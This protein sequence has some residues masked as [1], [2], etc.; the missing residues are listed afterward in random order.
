M[1][2]SQQP[3]LQIRH[4]GDLARADAV[5]HIGM[6][7]AGTGGGARRVEQDR[8]ERLLRHPFQR[9]GDHDFRDKPGARKVFANPVEPLGAVIERGHLPAGSGE[10][11]RLAAG[12]RAAIEHAAALA[13]PQQPRGQAGGKIL[14]PPRAFG[15]ALQLLDRRCR[16]SSRTW[17]GISEVPPSRSATARWTPD[18]ARSGR[19]AAAASPA[20][21]SGPLAPARRDAGRQGRRGG[22][23]GAAL[24]QRGEHPVRQPR[25]PPVSSGSAVA[26]T[27]C[28][29]VSSRS[30]PAS[31]SRSTIRA[32]WHRRA[33][34]VRVALSISASRSASQRS[35]SAAMARASALSA[36]P[37][38]P[39]V[40]PWAASSVSPRR[41]TA[42]SI[43]SAARRA[44]RPG[45]SFI[46][47]P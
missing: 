34:A 24:D 33:A 21:I 46:T 16:A 15:K 10:L 18:R 43:R 7:A 22:Q 4:L 13:C 23:A 2:R 20:A 9:I 40:A 37:R 6:A 35:A 47:A 45:M 42:S 30:Q 5:K 14:H 41:S 28:G 29:G 1:A 11:Q 17:P 38:M 32:A 44:A 25:G 36:A 19:A 12:R 31:I 39:C 27:A 8:V 3:F 26:I